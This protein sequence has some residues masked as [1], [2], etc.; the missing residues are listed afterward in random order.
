MAM[1]LRVTVAPDRLDASPGDALTVDVTIRNTSDVVEHYVVE[2]LGLPDGSTAHAE[3]EVTKLRP[4]ETGSATV[5]FTIRKQPPAPAGSQVL[6]VLVRSR[7]R[8]EASRCEELPLTVAPID[9]VAVR[10]EPEVATGKRSVR[11]AV[12]VTNQGNTPLRLRLTATDPERRVVPAFQPSIVELSPGAHARATLSVSAP[13]PWNREKQR[14]LKIEAAGVGVSGRANA[15]F[16]QRPRLAS[17]LARVGGMVGGVLV[18]AAAVVAAALIVNPGEPK[19]GGTPTPQAGVGQATAPA[20]VPTGPPSTAAAPSSAAPSAA[21]TPTAGAASTSAGAG[22]VGPREIDLTRPFAAAG[23]GIIPSD[24]FRQEGI[25]LSGLPDRDG[26][27]ECA[28][29]TAPAVR[30]DGAG[31][32]F[33]T[34]ALPDDPAACNYVPVQI[35]FT[36]KAA[37]VEVVLA[38]EGKRR[39]EVFYRDLSHTVE[40]DLKAEDDG[41]HGGIDYVV[42]RGIPADLTPEP[43]PAGVKILRY[44]PFQP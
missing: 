22:A 40:D 36:E 17:R 20:V 28:A 13:V 26:P 43:P 1:P 16:V 4:G 9:E 31:G 27:A 32:W 33:V 42:I 37:A 18:L 10:V 6:G 38:K 2:V 12:D 15:T 44:T 39:M 24:A 34:A 7:Y 25:T 8:E 29:A 35:R 14:A 19:E 30:A 5:T 23:G 21:A 11:Y 3:P 41:R